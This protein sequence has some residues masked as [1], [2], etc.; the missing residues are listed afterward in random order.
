MKI[1]VLIPDRSDRPDFLANTLRLIESQTVKPDHV[2]V[3]NFPATSEACDITVRYRYGYDKLSKMGFDVIFFMEN[4]DWYTNNYIETMLNAWKEAGEPDIFG[5]DYTF[6]YHIRQQGRFTM[7][8][9]NRSSAMSTLIKPNLIFEWPQDND[10]YTDVWLYTKLKYGVFHPD[11]K[12]PI[13]LGIKHGVG[14]CG[15]ECHTT[16]LRLFREGSGAFVDPNMVWL[17]SIVDEESFKF[18]HSISSQQNEANS[19]T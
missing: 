9:F 2:E 1:A 14:K 15:G 17:K 11:P 5:T 4:D 7:E 16:Y 3:V 18:Y 10:P 12:K 19:P 13:C 8:H 6:Y